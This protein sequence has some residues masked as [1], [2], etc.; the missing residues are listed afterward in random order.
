[1]AE[2]AAKVNEEVK[3]YIRAKEGY[4]RFL[5]K[6][7]ERLVLMRQKSRKLIKLIGIM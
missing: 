7:I 3:K 2:L 4:I 1:M 6:V 5:E